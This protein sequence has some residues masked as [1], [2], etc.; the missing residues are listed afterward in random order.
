[1]GKR[2]PIDPE[3]FPFSARVHRRM[4]A[5]RSPLELEEAAE[6]RRFLLWL[7]FFIGLFLL[8][9]LVDPVPRSGV[10]CAE[11][12]CPSAGELR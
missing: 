12:E 8:A 6:R 5:E 4:F 7:V 11:A 2:P 9:G 3:R 10:S 1:M